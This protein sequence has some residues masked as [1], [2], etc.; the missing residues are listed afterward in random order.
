MQWKL[1]HKVAAVLKCGEFEWNL[2]GNKWSQ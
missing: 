1:I 2:F